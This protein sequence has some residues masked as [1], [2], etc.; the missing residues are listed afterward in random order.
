MPDK[1]RWVRYRDDSCA[2]LKQLQ[3]LPELGQ[4]SRCEW[5]RIDDVECF[6]NRIQNVTGELPDRWW[7]HCCVGRSPSNCWIDDPDF[8]GQDH[9]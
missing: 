9:S 7:D 6:A 8:R 2:A 3:I 1:K 4:P 5:M